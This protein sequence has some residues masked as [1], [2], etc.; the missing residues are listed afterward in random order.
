VS[1]AAA[2]AC[3][4]TMLGLPLHAW[5]RFGV[6]LILGLVIYFA[7]GFRKSRFREQAPKPGA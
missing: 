1:L 6:W 2:A 3:L 7:Y 4:Y 5:E